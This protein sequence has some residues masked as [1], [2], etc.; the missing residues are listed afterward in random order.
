MTGDISSRST[1]HLSVRPA[2][3]PI[4]PEF[5]PAVHMIGLSTPIG[6][7]CHP[8]QYLADTW[9]TES[10]VAVSRGLYNQSHQQDLPRVRP[11]QK[12]FSKPRNKHHKRPLLPIQHMS[13]SR[14]LHLD[15]DGP[16]CG[17]AIPVPVAACP[18]REQ[19]TKIINGQSALLCRDGDNELVERN[20]LGLI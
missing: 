17:I 15:Q 8:V 14:K 13:V 18:F 11:R 6:R 1:P 10:S 3:R 20:P 7:T 12:K 4:A 9:S 16:L 2:L 19:F 5:V